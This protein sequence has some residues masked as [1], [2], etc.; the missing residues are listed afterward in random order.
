MS[1]IRDAA[2]YL[3]TYVEGLRGRD[4]AEAA[5]QLLL[6]G[7]IADAAER[8]LAAEREVAPNELC[9]GEEYEVLLRVRARVTDAQVFEEDDSDE[10]NGAMVKEVH[11][12]ELTL[13]RENF[14]S[15]RTVTVLESEIEEA[16]QI[17]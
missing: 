15:G 7:P 8:E 13:P 10:V 17:S 2:V 12:Y 4:D 6:W 14:V 1:A 3:C 5:R 9:E 16:S 11:V